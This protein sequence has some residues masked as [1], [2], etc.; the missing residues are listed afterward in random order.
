[1]YL[2]TYFLMSFV[3]EGQ[4]VWEIVSHLAMA[5]LTN[6]VSKFR[7]DD[8]AWACKSNA[9]QTDLR[10]DAIETD[11]RS[12][13]VCADKIPKNTSIALLTWCPLSFSS[14]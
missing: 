4:S 6:T 1:M 2:L 9:V 10:P 7:H 11:F 12:D 5:V 14:F 13:V 8:V 3:A